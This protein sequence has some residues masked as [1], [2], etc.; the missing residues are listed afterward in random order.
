MKKILLKL[1]F[2][3]KS[4]SIWSKRLIYNHQNESGMNAS[5]LLRNLLGFTFLLLILFSSCGEDNSD[6]EID[7]AFTSFVEQFKEEGKSRG[8]N[9]STDNLEVLFVNQINNNVAGCGQGFSDYQN[10]GN[11]RLEIAQN[12]WNE[13][14]ELEREHLIFHE[15]GHIILEREHDSAK[16]PDG[17]SPKSMMCFDCYPFYQYHEEGPLRDYYLDELFDPNTTFPESLSNKQLSKTL[18][19]EDASIDLDGWELYRK[20]P[21]TYDIKDY[22]PLDASEI[23]NE[24]GDNISITALGSDNSAIVLLKSFEI[25]IFNECS[26]LITTANISTEGMRSGNFQLG[27]TL[28]TLGT[29]GSL[30]RIFHTRQMEDQFTSSTNE[31]SNVKVASY[32]IPQQTDF[33]TVSITLYSIGQAKLIL[34]NVKVELFE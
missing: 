11:L 19:D 7:P 10:S 14:N 15:L 8:Q 2:I 33:V 24:E 23:N 25:G 22:T 6:L 34:D 16:L 4:Q 20:E 28:Q 30:N 31:F 1:I 17:Y 9:I 13:L 18:L 29:D 5:I 32:C 27:L 12:C 3:I 26:N 21:L